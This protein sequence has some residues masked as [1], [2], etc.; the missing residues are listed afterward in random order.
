MGHDCPLTVNM[1]DSV[2]IF[3]LFPLPHEQG[4][5]QHLQLALNQY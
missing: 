4:Q 2:K 1:H 5:G 3:T